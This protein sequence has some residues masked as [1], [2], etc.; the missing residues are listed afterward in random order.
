MNKKL[1]YIGSIILG[2][3]FVAVTIFYWVTPAGSLPSYMPG[4]IAGSS[5]IHI[6]HGIASL[7]LAIG[8]FI[9][10]WFASA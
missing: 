3:L 1:F 6:K 5:V 8:L 7:I 4:F 2:M 10:S 9:Y